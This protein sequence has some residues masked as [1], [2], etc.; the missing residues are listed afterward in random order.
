MLR[1][2]NNGFDWFVLAGALTNV[3]VISIIVVN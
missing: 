1:L 3:I 2:P